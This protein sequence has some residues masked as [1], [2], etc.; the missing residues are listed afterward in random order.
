MK[1]LKLGGT[2]KRVPYDVGTIAPSL[3]WTT[4]TCLPHDLC[5]I[6][7]L[8]SSCRPGANLQGKSTCTKAP[9][10]SGAEKP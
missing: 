2:A 7:T 5:A 8:G 1:G 3:M 10:G 6:R 9:T 4:V